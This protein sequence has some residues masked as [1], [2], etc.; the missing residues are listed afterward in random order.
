[1]GYL[2][3]HDAGKVVLIEAPVDE[4]DPLRVGEEPTGQC[5]PVHRVAERE[6]HAPVDHE[7][8]YLGWKARARPDDDRTRDGVGAEVADEVAFLNARSSMSRLLGEQPRLCELGSVRVCRAVRVQVPLVV[9]P[10][11]CPAFACTN[12]PG[13]PAAAVSV[14]AGVAHAVPRPERGWHV[15][16]G[17]RLARVPRELR[18]FERRAVLLAEHVG[19]VRDGLVWLAWANS[20]RT[21]WSIV[22][23]VVLDREF[24]MREF[25]RGFSDS[26]KSATRFPCG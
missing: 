19:R 20:C 9:Q 11:A 23:R 21:S 4:Q 14:S 15:R 25:A 22:G 3:G 1:M 26:A 2:V 10:C 8:E 12:M 7:V 24:F 6:Q 16:P 18:G 5:L 13:T 17:Q